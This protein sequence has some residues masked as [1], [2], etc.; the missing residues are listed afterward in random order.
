MAFVYP[1]SANHVLR[2]AWGQVSLAVAA[3]A[4]S[5]AVLLASH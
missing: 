3:E 1:A 4:G 2:D 5:K